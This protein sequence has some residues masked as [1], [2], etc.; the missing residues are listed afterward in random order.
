MLGVRLPRPQETEKGRRTDPVGGRLRLQLGQFCGIHGWQ[1]LLCRSV[2][3]NKVCWRSCT[4]I[5][6]QAALGCLFRSSEIIIVKNG[7][8]FH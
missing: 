2:T 3:K 6:K 8:I 1:L 5:C 4:N 7:R